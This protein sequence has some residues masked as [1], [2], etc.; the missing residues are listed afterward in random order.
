MKSISPKPGADMRVSGD[1]GEA[2]VAAA[3]HHELPGAHLE[4][5]F[6]E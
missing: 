5:L 1:V 2:R 3:V 4:L 6:L